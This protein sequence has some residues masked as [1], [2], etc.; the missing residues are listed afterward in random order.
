MGTY[1]TNYALYK[2]TVGERGWGT[3]VDDT[4]DVIDETLAAIAAS[5]GTGGGHVIQEAGAPFTQRAALNFLYNEVL[6]DVGNNATIV[7]A[8]TGFWAPLTNGD[9]DAPELV[10]ID[11]DVVMVFVEV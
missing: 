1:T 4:L 11:G 9:A 6:D 10:F 5:V 8:A 3:L 7:G 2:P